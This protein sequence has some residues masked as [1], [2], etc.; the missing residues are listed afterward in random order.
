MAKI[1]H[2]D[3]VKLDIFKITAIWDLTLATSKAEASNGR[4]PR[5]RPMLR[6][7]T[8]EPP[9]WLLLRPLTHDSVVEEEATSRDPAEWDGLLPTPPVLL[10]TALLVLVRCQPLLG[11]GPGS[12]DRMARPTVAIL[13]SA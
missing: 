7:P 12:P 11:L 10:E 13:V 4:F 1:Q 6:T 3:G 2:G 5:R 8:S 9:W